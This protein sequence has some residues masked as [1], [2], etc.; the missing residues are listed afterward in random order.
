M[1][2]PATA[3][4]PITEGA[5]DFLSAVL[6]LPNGIVLIVSLDADMPDALFEVVRLPMGAGDTRLEFESRDPLGVARAAY[7]TTD[8]VL[9][10][11]AKYAAAR[12]PSPR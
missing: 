8:H 5:L 1:R 9:Q 2:S 10:L 7:L 11:V 4:L 3:A 12:P 6:T